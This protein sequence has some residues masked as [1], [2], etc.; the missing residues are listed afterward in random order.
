MFTDSFRLDPLGYPMIKI[1]GAACF[2]HCL[3]VTKLQFE[4]FL[5]EARDGHFTAAWYEQVL[6][7]NP[8]V[9]ARRVWRDNYWRAF[10]TG[11]LPAEAER[12]AA[13]C[14]EGYRLPSDAEWQRLFRAASGAG[15]TRLGELGACAGIGAPQRELLAGVERA[16]EEVCRAVAAPCRL[17]ER[18]LLR[19]GVVE[20]V[21]TAAHGDHRWA[22]MGEPHPSFCGNLF[23]PDEE[24]PVVPA[25]PERERL[26][27][28]G[29]RLVYTPTPSYGEVP[30]GGAAVQ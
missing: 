18:L 2:V 21:T 15:D 11:V 26:A 23:A 5:V 9:T 3:P 30:P 17:A 8:R 13:W 16:V 24:V 7:L 25:E 20:W 27:S 10:L 19:L 14:G 6:E 1:P 28:F 4:R 22:G 12:F 29:F